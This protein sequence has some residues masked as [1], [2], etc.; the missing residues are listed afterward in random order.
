M[1]ILNT[2]KKCIKCK[3]SIAPEIAM[4]VEF[5]NKVVLTTMCPLCGKKRIK[6][7]KKELYGKLV[8]EY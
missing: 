4:E 7:I 5:E 2:D 6:T 8:L 1:K 3:L